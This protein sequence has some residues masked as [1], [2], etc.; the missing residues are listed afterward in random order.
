MALP[1]RLAD[2]HHRPRDADVELHRVADREVNA[3]FYVN[4]ESLFACF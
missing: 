2:R 1:L 3:R 4:G